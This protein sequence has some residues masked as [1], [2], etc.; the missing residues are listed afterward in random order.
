MKNKKTKMLY[1]LMYVVLILLCIATVFPV[2]Y[3]ILGAFKTNAEVTLG[4]TIIPKKWVF[5]N[6]VIALKRFNFA[7]YSL[8]SII[9]AVGVTVGSI[10]VSSMTGYCVARK[11]FPGKKLFMGVL[12][13]TMFISVGTVTLKPLYLLFVKLGLQN[14]LL[15]I[16]LILIGANMNF[17]IFLVSRF[18]QGVPKELDESA[19]IDGAGFFRIYWQII[20]P[21]IKPILGVVG[22]FSFRGAW[23]NY[24]HSSIFTMTNPNLRPLTVGVVSLK[25][26]T[27]AAI[28]WNIMLAGASLAIIPML[29]VYIFANKTFISGLSEGAVK[30]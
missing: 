6:Y 23:N 22:L 11:D 20:L 21:L 12:L 26:G 25:Y 28:E 24:I 4:G 27:E 18:V 3:A 9:I 16:I 15:P 14:S 10:I 1:A 29:I 13:G 7:R 2:F 17:N 5:D 30:G 8:N 19:T